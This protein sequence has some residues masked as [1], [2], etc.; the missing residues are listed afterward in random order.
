M[1]IISDDEHIPIPRNRLA[2]GEALAS[3]EL[4]VKTG[5]A[6]YYDVRND[7]LQVVDEVACE[8]KLMIQTEV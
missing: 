8:M 3:A 5:H 1:I 6:S 2:N 7:R 4:P